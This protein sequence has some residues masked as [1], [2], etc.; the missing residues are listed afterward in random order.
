MKLVAEANTDVYVYSTFFYPK[1]VRFGSQAVCRWTK[2]TDLFSKRLLLVPVH[3]GAHWCLASISTADL[4]IVYYDSLHEP[5]P[6]CLE[7]LKLYI[8]EK[9]SNCASTTEWNCST[10][11]GVPQQTNNSDCGVFVCRIAQCLANKT[12]FNFSQCDMA[13]IRREMVLELLLQK[14]LP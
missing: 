3:L 13:S 14:L 5:N 8:L 4:Q 11:Q 6:A 12:S 9:S 1:L 2:E 10:S 7:A